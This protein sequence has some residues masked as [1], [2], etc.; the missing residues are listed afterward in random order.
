MWYGDVERST[1]Y[2]IGFF[3]LA[4]LSIVFFLFIFGA[5]SFGSGTGGSL[6]FFTR[7]LIYSPLLLGVAMFVAGTETLKK[8]SW[9][10]KFGLRSIAAYFIFN[11]GVFLASSV[12]G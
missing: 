5:A 9:G 2:A 11:V 6:D 3:I 8:K 10:I 1:K 12:F 7:S 4:P